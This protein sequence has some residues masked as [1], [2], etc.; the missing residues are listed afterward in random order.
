LGINCDNISN[1]E[2]NDIMSNIKG[3]QGVFPLDLL[4]K[5]PGKCGIINLDIS[6]GNGTHWVCWYNDLDFIE[7]FD[8]YGEYKLN[9]V[10]LTKNVIPREIVIFLKKSG[11]DIY[12]NDGFLQGITSQKCGCFC[13]YYIINRSRGIMPLDIL[14]SFKQH[15]SEYNENKILEFF[16]SF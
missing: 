8:P 14:N 16:L 7:Y 1:I 9:K 2:I 4:P 15:P 11:K 13:M 10:K 12:Y 5:K 6:S 3:F